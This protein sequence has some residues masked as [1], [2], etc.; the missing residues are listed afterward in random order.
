MAGFERSQGTSH[1]L[2]GKLEFNNGLAAKTVKQALIQAGFD[3]QV[4]RE[5]R[6]FTEKIRVYAREVI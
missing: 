5:E 1:V 6:N 3:L 2:V 4:E